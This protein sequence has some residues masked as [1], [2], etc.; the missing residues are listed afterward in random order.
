[1][2]LSIAL[3][4]FAFSLEPPAISFSPQATE[5]PDDWFFWQDQ[6]SSSHLLAIAAQRQPEDQLIC[7]KE[8]I[9]LRELL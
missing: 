7:C 1:M 2:G 5:K 3:S 8:Q 6:P 4:E 9:A